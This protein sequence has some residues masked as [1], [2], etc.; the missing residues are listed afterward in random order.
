M[1]AMPAPDAASA[2]G[3]TATAAAAPANSGPLTGT[4]LIP[5]SARIDRADW[6]QA[7]ALTL[8]GTLPDG[9]TMVIDLA[10]EELGRLRITLTLEGDRAMIQFQTETPEAARLLS[11]HERAL[12]TELARSGMNLAGH[13]AQSGGA[14]AAPRTAT[15]ASGSGSASAGDDR[16]NAPFPP[17]RHR[18]SINLIA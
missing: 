18:G 15:R 16:P 1:A 9:G 10:P 7:M 8:T 11:Q 13:D 4:A 12:S 3:T 5:M 6:P 2:P 14:W 17:P